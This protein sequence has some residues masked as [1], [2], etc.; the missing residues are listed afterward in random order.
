YT[1]TL[2]GLTA[3]IR[4]GLGY[5][6]TDAYDAFGDLTSVQKQLTASVNTTT[7]YSYDA[8]GERI[9]EVDDAGG[10]NRAT[11]A[12]YDAFGRVT[13]R[14][15]GNGNTVSYGYDT[16]G[17][18]ISISEIVQGTARTTRT[19]YDAYGRTLTQT[20]AQGNVTAYQ[21]SA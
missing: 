12:T 13:S 16:L 14:T 21:Y 20:D 19:T 1:Y 6:A 5:T 3:S 15:D 18:Q 7:T 4:D 2:N 11:G 9:G 17:R 8:R 10:L